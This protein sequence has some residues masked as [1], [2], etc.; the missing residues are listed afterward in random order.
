MRPAVRSLILGGGIGSPLSLPNLERWYDPSDA[1]TLTLNTNKVTAIADKS[2][3]A[4][5]LGQSTDASR[6]TTG[7]TING[8]PALT[9]DGTNDALTSISI[10]HYNTEDAPF[11]LFYH[12]VGLDR[13]VLCLWLQPPDGE[14][15]GL[16]A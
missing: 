3:N 8:V 5:D 2:G 14:M 6:P 9:F 1:S 12:Q 13:T 15:A 16:Q 10:T 4:R 7:S 11:T